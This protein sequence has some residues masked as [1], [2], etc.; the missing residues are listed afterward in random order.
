M[1]TK[2][3]KVYVIVV[4]ET[5]E[6]LAAFTTKDQAQTVMRRWGNTTSDGKEIS[7]NEDH[8]DDYTIFNELEAA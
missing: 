1:N 7:I 5:Q 8:V 2:G 6:F 4:T 3:S